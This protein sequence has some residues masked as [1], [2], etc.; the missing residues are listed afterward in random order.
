MKCS[1]A[2]I[3]IIFVGL[4]IACSNVVDDTNVPFDETDVIA[5]A[6]ECLPDEKY[7]PETNT[8]YIEIEI[9]CEDDEDCEDTDYWEMTEDDCLPGESYDPEEAVCYIECESDLECQLLEGEI[10]DRLAGY[11]DEAFGGH[12]SG[13]DGRVSEGEA[14]YEDE[15]PSIARYEL[16]EQLD[17]VLIE[18]DEAGVEQA[19]TLKESHQAIWLFTRQILPKKVLRE[20]VR[21]FHVFTDGADNTLAYVSPL[22]DDP[23]LWQ[24]AIDIEDAGSPDQLSQQQDFIHTLIHEFAHIITLE[25]DQVPPDLSITE[26][27]REEGVPSPTELACET[28]FTGEG[29]AKEQSYINLFFDRF[30]GDIY[31]ELYEIDEVAE[32]DEEYEEMLEDFY[33]DYQDRFVTEYASTNPGEDIAESFTFFVLKD[34][35]DGAI[36]AEEKV[37]FF[38]EFDT[39]VEMRTQIRRQ[40]ARLN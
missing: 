29:C 35:P 39:L 14:D 5:D 27:E 11:F 6:S 13:S 4:L 24:F 26:E 2:P 36:I 8:C 31:D 7:D 25:N 23:N 12:R 3:V 19:H 22:V 17:L 10:Y 20:E 16:N 40:L 21:E 9:D 38:Y 33:L 28:F 1:F 18:V 37:R 32:T 30:W 34:K 15:L